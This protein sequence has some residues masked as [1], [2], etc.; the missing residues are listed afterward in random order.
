MIV[1]I[2]HDIWD[3]W[4]DK[5]SLREDHKDEYP[6]GFVWSCCD[7]QVDVKYGCRTGRH[8]VHEVKVK[9]LKMTKK[10]HGV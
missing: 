4:N 6:E 8:K 2:E 7:K 5:V 1:D 10:Q 3:D 9:V